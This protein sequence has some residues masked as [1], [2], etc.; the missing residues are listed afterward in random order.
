MIMKPNQSKST[1]KVD[2]EPSPTSSLS[3]PDEGF[4][5]LP[6]IERVQ[7]ITEQTN[8]QLKK[9]IHAKSQKEK[10]NKTYE[11]VNPQKEIFA[12]IYYY[13]MGVSWLK[14]WGIMMIAYV[15]TASL[16]AALL[17]IGGLQTHFEEEVYYYRIFCFCMQIMSTHGGHLTPRTSYA[18]TL[19]TLQA[20]IFTFCLAVI[21]GLIFSKF[22]KPSARIMF[23][24]VVTIT[25][26]EGKLC[27]ILRV[28]NLR[29]SCIDNVTAEM[30]V[31]RNELGPGD[32][33]LTR[34][35]TSVPLLRAVNP[36]FGLTWN[37]VHVIDKT[38]ILYGVSPQMLFDLDIIVMV[39]IMGTE[40]VFSATVQAGQMY[41]PDT[42][43]FGHKFDDIFIPAGENKVNIELA[44]LHDT[45]L[46]ESEFVDQKL[47]ENVN[48]Y[49][50]QKKQRSLY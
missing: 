29:D 1:A 22:A 12:D 27:L 20:V 3:D 8:Q 38:S 36:S 48:E 49:T 7:T 46:V 10:V 14:F 23:S 33:F 47:K 44:K 41:R 30:N 25:D 19:V 15:T 43:L 13:F 31:Y 26:R 21:T 24:K 28:A 45:H 40:T 39:N 2:V 17:N 4:D 37:V 5:T 9:L 50:R 35:W 42:I 16:F 11:K 18:E 34:T 32:K 6:V